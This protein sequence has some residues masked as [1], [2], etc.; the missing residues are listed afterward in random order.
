MGK[1]RKLFLVLLFFLV[2]T[3]PF[4]AKANEFENPK[5]IENLIEGYYQLSYDIYLSMEMK[6][7]DQ[8]LDYDSIQ[9]RNKITALQRK[10]DIRKYKIEK[11]YPNQ[12]RERYPI[13]FN[14]KSI[15][16]D[17]SK[18][19]AT[20]VVDITGRITNKQEAYPMFVSFGENKFKLKLKNENWVI[21]EHDYYDPCFEIPKNELTEYSRE[22]TFEE[23]D[24]EYGNMIF[25]DIEK[26]DE[27]I[28]ADPYTDVPYSR[29]RATSYANTFVTYGNNY[30]YPADNDCTNFISQCIAYGFGYATEYSNSAAYRQVLGIWSA[31]SGG[32]Y[33]AWESV[34]SN[35]N[36]MTSSKS[37]STEG[38]RV[39]ITSW[40][41][42]LDGG[43]MQIDF[44]E[45]G[46]YDH[47]TI[48]VS[49]SL[50]KFAQHS[51]NLFRN[52][53]AYQGTK[54]FYQPSYF[55]EF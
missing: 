12:G 51:D 45:D 41:S 54:R 31:G 23:I 35:W 4:E 2:L 1:G 8:Y 7:M 49:K 26:S 50:E 10:V 44:S 3:V 19:E 17:V 27:S 11:G 18:A 5:F 15:N 47:S 42:L 21:Y 22:R 28:L 34:Q 6:P 37:S 38:P 20:V 29:S 24:N 53:D 39:S 52:Y 14:Y 46:V 40:G 9:S 30:F 33:P 55:R 16:I 32:G 13:F 43:I 48:C 25:S 36:Y